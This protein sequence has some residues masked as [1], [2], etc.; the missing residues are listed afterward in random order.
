MVYDKIERIGKE[1]RLTVMSVMVMLFPAMQPRL[2]LL[3]AKQ[4]YLLGSVKC[5]D[6]Y[7]SEHSLISLKEMLAVSH[8]S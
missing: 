7:R 6:Y 8:L 3:Y 4:E 2:L 5:E 1:F